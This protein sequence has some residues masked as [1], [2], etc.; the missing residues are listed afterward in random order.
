MLSTL[1]QTLMPV[2]KSTELGFSLIEL[3][4]TIAIIAIL[5]T[6]AIPGYQDYVTKAKITT[7]QSDLTSLALHFENRYQR[8]LSYPA[9]AYATTAELRG[10]MT[11]WTPATETADFNFLSTNA[12]TTEYTIQAIGKGGPLKDCAISLTRTGVKSISDCDNYS[13]GEWL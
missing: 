5:A 7:A 13:S 6:F 2:E 1:T 12:S 9:D 3:I 10:A 11:G 4:I 8:L